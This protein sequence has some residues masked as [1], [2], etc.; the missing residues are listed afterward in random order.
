MTRVPPSVSPNYVFPAPPS[1]PSFTA[2]QQP[3]RTNAVQAPASPIQAPCATPAFLHPAVEARLAALVRKECE[4]VQ[5]SLAQNAFAYQHLE[6]ELSAQMAWLGCHSEH[7]N[8][9]LSELLTLMSNIKIVDLVDRSIYQRQKDQGAPAP[10]PADEAAKP[11]PPLVDDKGTLYY[12][13]GIVIKN[14]GAHVPCTHV[15]T[16]YPAPSKS[17]QDDYADYA[18]MPALVDASVNTP[19]PAAEALLASLA[20]AHLVP[21]KTTVAN[22]AQDSKAAA[23]HAAPLAAVEQPHYNKAPWVIVEQPDDDSDS[24]DSVDSEQECEYEQDDDEEQAPPSSRAD[25]V[26][27]MDEA[28]RAAEL[29]VCRLEVKLLTAQLRLAQKQLEQFEGGFEEV[30]EVEEAEDEE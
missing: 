20:A 25:S 11:M 28:E 9:M 29:R 18:D 14:S 21:P 22:T 1:Q 7:T 10:I 5:L 13:N 2:P 4:S 30:K 17:A 6:A 23:T 26:L 8:R 24:D 27:D 19:N 15:E 12:G 3:Y 16:S